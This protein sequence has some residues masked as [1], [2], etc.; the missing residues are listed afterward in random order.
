MQHLRLMLACLASLWFCSSALAAPAQSSERTPDIEAAI[1]KG[2]EYLK[3]AYSNSA[4]GRRSLLAYALLKAGYPVKSPEVSGAINEILATISDGKYNAKGGNERYYQAAVHMMLLVDAEDEKYRPQVEAI[5]RYL[6]EEQLP[7][8]SWDYHRNRVGDTSVTQ[9]ALLGLWAAAR[10]G[11]E[12]PMQVWDRAAIWHVRTQYDYGGHAYQPRVEIGQG[13]GKPTHNMT[14]AAVGSMLVTRLYLFP[15]EGE[16][17]KTRVSSD[18]SDA[19]KKFGVLE[20]TDVDAD[21]VANAEGGL[22][23]LPNLDPNYK[24]SV[25]KTSLDQAIKGGLNWISNHFVAVPDKRT[26]HLYYYYTMER[27]TALA[28]IAEIDQKDWFKVCAEQVL[29][30]QEGDGKWSSRTGEI[31]GTSFCILFLTQSTAKLLGRPVPGKI[32]AGLLAGGRGLPDSLDEVHVK[33]GKVAEDKLKDPLSK[34]LADLEKPDSVLLDSVQSA[35]IEKVQVGDRE[36]LIGQRDRLIR[37]VSH[38]S[39]EVRRMAF[40]ALGRS[41]NISDASLMIRALK[42]EVDFDVLVEARNAL[43]FLS[44]KPNGLGLPGDPLTGVAEDATEDQKKAAVDQWRAQVHKRWLI[45]YLRVRPYQEQD[46]F[47]ETI[48]DKTGS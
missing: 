6:V 16:F 32:G 20:E 9:Y 44:H 28:N 31:P 26:S 35:L 11:I 30:M 2:A 40:W 34:L 37:L 29:L 48:L 47:A 12:I 5:A 18:K 36:E 14:S 23:N 21:P 19:K 10:I 42:E 17:N 13:K 25:T 39:P 8:G 4:G 33:D 43:C 7:N 15:E 46:D 22:E 1:Q 38:P 27:M 41:D 3:T 24:R 45:W